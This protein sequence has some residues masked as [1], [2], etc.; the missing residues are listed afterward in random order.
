MVKDTSSLK[1]G[2]KDEFH[3]D[4]RQASDS[5]FHRTTSPGDGGYTFELLTA[6]VEGNCS[7]MQEIDASKR[8][9][10]SMEDV[11]IR[12]GTIRMHL[13]LV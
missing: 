13:L 9:F 4:E 6:T 12:S 3:V 2:S 5:S 7:T 11:S 1:G 8:H 10:K